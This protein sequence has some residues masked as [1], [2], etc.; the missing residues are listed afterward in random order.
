MIEINNYTYI[1]IYPRIHL[2]DSKEANKNTTSPL[3]L[4]RNIK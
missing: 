2:M 1:L 4:S 3:L